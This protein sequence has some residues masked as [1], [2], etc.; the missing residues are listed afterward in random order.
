MYYIS[1][2]YMYYQF[3]LHVLSVPTTCIISSY[4]MYYQFLLHVLSVPTACIISSYC[5]YIISSCSFT[6]MLTL[7]REP[8]YVHYSGQVSHPIFQ[9][10]K[11]PV[12][13]HPLSRGF[14]TLRIRAREA[15]GPGNKYF[16]FTSAYSRF[17]LAPRY[18]PIPNFFWHNR[19]GPIL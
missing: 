18:I 6:T 11:N 16:R 7:V 4:Y 13:R 8:I 3:L 10:R 5:M 9:S 1:S 2:Y 19:R 14:Y 15:R 17:I 12:Q